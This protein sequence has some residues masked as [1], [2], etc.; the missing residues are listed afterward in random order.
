M[1]QVH[2]LST[3][4]P[5]LRCPQGSHLLRRGAFRRALDANMTR[6]FVVNGDDMTRVGGG[7]VESATGDRLQCAAR[8]K[9]TINAAGAVHKASTA[10]SFTHS[11]HATARCAIVKQ[12]RG[13]TMTAREDACAIASEIE[14]TSTLDA[15]VTSVGFADLANPRA[16]DT[17]IT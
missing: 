2:P 13:T 1:C 10:L 9:P 16:R 4:N 6:A 15:C 17:C 7:G 14:V 12:I 3:T 8:S 5:T 11:S